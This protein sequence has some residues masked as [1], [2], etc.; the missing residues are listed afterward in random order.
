V[1]SE[2][3]HSL[4]KVFFVFMAAL[5]IVFS[6]VQTSFA[7]EPLDDGV[8][9]LEYVVL[10]AQ[11]D[12]VSIANDYFE[13]PATLFVKNGETFVRFT[14]NHS[15]WVKELQAPLGN[16]FVDVQ[17]VSEDK[18]NDLREVQFKVDSDLNKPL[19]LKMHVYIETMDPVYDH[20][21]TVR[22]DFDLDSL[23]ENKELTL[24]DLQY[25]NPAGNKSTDESKKVDAEKADEQS[26]AS[27]MIWIVII[28]VVFLAVIIFL[29]I[30]IRKKK[31]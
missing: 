21:Y 6:N 17:V 2:T 24:S 15:Q 27:N 3:K 30:K 14:I 26:S 4:S 29:F 9:S 20:R 7:S 8:Y 12:S 23:Q 31:E 13:K 19:E 25:E 22:L 5:A 28:T 16:S 1:T 10:H 11:N 18:S